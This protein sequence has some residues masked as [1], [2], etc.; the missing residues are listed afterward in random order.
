MASLDAF[1]RERMPSP[2]VTAGAAFAA[3]ALNMVCESTTVQERREPS[4]AQLLH[5]EV[6]CVAEYVRFSELHH[7]LDGG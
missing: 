1:P 6:L 4:V 5:H 7:S 3:A 2:E